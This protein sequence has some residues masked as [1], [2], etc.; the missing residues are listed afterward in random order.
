MSFPI[1]CLT[2][3][4]V[5]GGRDDVVSHTVADLELGNCKTFLGNPRRNDIS[6]DIVWR[7]KSELPVPSRR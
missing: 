3:T 4:A 5:Y 6:F 2:A 1:F 7:S